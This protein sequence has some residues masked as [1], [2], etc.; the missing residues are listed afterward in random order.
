MP[1]GI[2]VIFHNGSNS[3][4]HF[5][6][7][8]LANEFKGQFE[9]LR[10]NTAKYKTFSVLIENEIRKVNKDGINNITTVSY[11]IKLI[12]SVKFMGKFIIKSC[13]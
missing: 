13:W 8:E 5:I 4:H 1:S 9:Y 12:D 7:K 11:K 3:D 10:E 6:L 2:P